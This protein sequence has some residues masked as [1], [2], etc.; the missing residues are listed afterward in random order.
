ML[1]T[2]REYAFERLETAS[3]AETLRDRHAAWYLALSERAKPEL[4]G[5]RAASWL[6]RL[7]AE[8]DNLRMVLGRVLA[9][10]D[11]EGALRLTGAIWTFWQTRGYWSE[12]RRWLEAA[13]AIAAHAEPKSRVDAQWGAALLAL[14]QGDTDTA[15]T[16]SDA[17]LTLARE[18]R[19]IR[20]EAIALELLAIVAAHLADYRRAA[21]LF[22]QALPLAYEADDQWLVS[23]ILNNLGDTALNEG[24]FKLAV[25]FFERSL[26]VGEA[27]GDQD[28]RARALTNLGAAM[29][30]LDDRE[31]A[32]QFFR[33][34]LTAATEVGLREILLY[35][36]LGLACS[37]TDTDPMLS[38]QLLGS[39]DAATE[40]LEAN[41]NDFESRM[42]AEAID[43]L[44]IS[45][46]EQTWAA[47]YA[48][49][50]TL[51][52]EDAVT[53]AFAS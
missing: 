49:G 2:I 13:L 15:T 45:L 24:D 31:R 28:R 6:D 17:L 32:R 22:E 42:H 53:H 43:T 14:W 33:E 39:V 36:L 12:G 34:G 3:D 9:Q 10:A 48:E 38:A 18:H 4:H 25:S 29:L 8:H 50:R 19:M 30:A 26:V 37:S 47:T 16:H 11:A 44:R 5:A 20:A 27:R 40:A 46:G 41:I 1:E 52:L 21:E 35:G 7:E 51:T 23:V